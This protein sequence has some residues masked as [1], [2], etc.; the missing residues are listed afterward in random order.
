MPANLAPFAFKPGQSGNPGGRGGEY[1]EAQEICRDAAPEAAR[2]IIEL[3]QSDDDRVRLMAAKEIFDRAFGRPK[4]F[5]PKGEP[6]AL[7]GLTSAQQK[8][9]VAELLAFAA[10]LQVPETIP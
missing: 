6:D 3:L 7:A 9:R 5:N 2:V 4:E 1:Y 8:A 10:T